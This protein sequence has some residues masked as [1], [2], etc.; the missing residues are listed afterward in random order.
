MYVFVWGSIWAPM[1]GS[2]LWNTLKNT[3]VADNKAEPQYLVLLF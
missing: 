2:G 3:W 1:L